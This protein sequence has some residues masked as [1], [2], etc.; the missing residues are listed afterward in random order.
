M[1]IHF[2]TENNIQ[3]NNK[4]G[5]TKYIKQL[6]KYYKEVHNINMNFFY[7]EL[8]KPTFFKKILA[9][10]NLILSNIPVQIQLRKD[11]NY[12]LEN[13]KEDLVFIESL[14]LA[15]F[16]K[17][18]KNAVLLAQDSLSRLQF[19]IAKG[20]KN[21]FKK[22]YYAISGL[23]YL[24]LEEQLYKEFK[25]VV[26][27]SKS[28]IKYVESQIETGNY[29][30]L[31]VGLNTEELYTYNDE[32][33]M[34]KI[35]NQFNN[36]IIFTGNMSYPPNDEAAQRLINEI[37]PV[38]KNNHKDLKLLLVGL[39]SEKYNAPDKS[40]I[41]LGIV[42]SLKEYIHCSNAYVSPL[43]SGSGMK[44]KILEALAQGSLVIATG[45]SIEGIN[46]LT[47]GFNFLRADTNS[48]IITKIDWVIKNNHES[49]RIKN[50]GCDFVLQNH[51]FNNKNKEK[52]DSFLKTRVD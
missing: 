50:Q 9:L 15:P 22:I 33:L 23:A 35:K 41:G 5:S 2:Y 43:L 31:E 25:K 26:F 51:I 18:K 30:L 20:Q 46:G 1:D 8:P 42:S 29:E 13:S 49:N 39:G 14:Y 32:N 36:Y 7:Y 47:D 11:A 52:L 40:V 28:D 37:F 45:K 10:L 34:K 17:N 3:H 4:V 24:S 38:I 6:K 27:V 12:K 21:I 44:N 19:S 48:E 16:V